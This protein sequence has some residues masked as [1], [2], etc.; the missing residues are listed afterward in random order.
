MN[1]SAVIREKKKRIKTVILI[2]VITLICVLLILWFF[3]YRETNRKAIREKAEYYS[4]GEFVSLD[5]NF[6]IDRAE[7]LNGYSIR[8]NN[9]QLVDYKT[10]IEE[11]GGEV[12]TPASDSIKLPKYMIL[13]NITM[14]N[15]GNKDGAYN[16]QKLALYNKSLKIPVDVDAWMQAD[17]NYTGSAFLMLIENSEADITIPFTPFVSVASTNPSELEKVME[18]EKFYFCISEFPVRKMIE[19]TISK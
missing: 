15:E 10:Y 16:V 19:V 2:A 13:L 17:K 5:D 11:N 9:A 18:N 3:Q 14:K 6:F 8:V 12:L 4:M 7:N 1:N